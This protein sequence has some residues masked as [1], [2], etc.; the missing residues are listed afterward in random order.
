MYNI[1]IY[2]IIFII[3]YVYIYIYIYILHVYIYIISGLVTTRISRKRRIGHE[4]KSLPCLE[5]K[6]RGL[7]AHAKFEIA[8]PELILIYLTEFIIH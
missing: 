2:I 8:H 5:A 6:Q 4:M 1:Y 7:I 3:I